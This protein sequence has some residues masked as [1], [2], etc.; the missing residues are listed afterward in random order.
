MYPTA[1]LYTPYEHKY[2][3]NNVFKVTIKNIPSNPDSTLYYG[4]FPNDSFRW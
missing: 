2:V 4:Y 1:I 3:K